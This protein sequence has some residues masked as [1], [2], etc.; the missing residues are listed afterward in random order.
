MYVVK[1]LNDVIEAKREIDGAGSQD[2]SNSSSPSKSQQYI[3]LPEQLVAE[4]DY[5]TKTFTFLQNS[6]MKITRFLYFDLIEGDDEAIKE[7]LGGRLQLSLEYLV[8]HQQVIQQG[9]LELRSERSAHAATQQLA[10]ELEARISEMNDRF[11]MEKNEYAIEYTT[12][13]STMQVDSERTMMQQRAA[14]STE[15]NSLKQHNGE[16]ENKVAGTFHPMLI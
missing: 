3:D 13:L 7:Y 5:S 14:F 6:A 2:R 10:E 1:L 16:L 12:K 15:L 8:E 4:F 9:Q 11:Q